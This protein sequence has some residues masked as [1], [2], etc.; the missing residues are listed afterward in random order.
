MPSTTPE[1]STQTTSQTLTAPTILSADQVSNEKS[2]PWRAILT[3][4]S[5]VFN[6]IFFLKFEIFLHLKLQSNTFLA[7]SQIYKIL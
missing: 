6:H 4:F 2:I 5:V 3:R 1:T 7:I